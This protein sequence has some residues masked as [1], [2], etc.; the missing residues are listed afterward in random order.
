M[1]HVQQSYLPVIVDLSEFDYQSGT[2][3]ER[4]VFNHRGIV[5]L[6]CALTTLILG[7]QATK[8]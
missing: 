4:L 7:F 6:L 1:A 3:L 5:F 2:F 8:I